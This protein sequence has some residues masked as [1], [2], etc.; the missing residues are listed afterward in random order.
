[1]ACAHATLGQATTAPRS[2]DLP[3]LLRA[4][5]L[6]NTSGL[7][8]GVLPQGITAHGIVWLKDVAFWDGT[9][10]VDLRGKDVFLQSFLGLAF[11]GTD[12][13]HYETVY[14]R[15]FNFRHADTLRRKW[16][17]QYMS[18]PDAPYNKLRAEH[19][20]T[21]ENAVDPVP[22]ATE[23]F[24]A[25][26]VIRDGWV[27]VYVNHSAKASLQVKAAVPLNGTLLGLWAD[28]LPGD[29]AHLTVTPDAGRA[30][31]DASQTS[32]TREAAQAAPDA[33]QTTPAG[34]TVVN[35][36][37]TR[38]TEPG[39]VHM[40]EVDGDGIAWI[41]GQ[42]LTDG[43]LEFDV[44]GKDVLQRSFVGI[45]FHGVNDSTFE[46][47]YFRPFNFRTDD[48]VR[49]THAVQYIAEPSYGWEKLRT[50]YPNK[51]EQPLAPAPDPN[52]WFHVRV[53][54][55]GSA[56]T[57]Y[58]NGASGPSLVVTSLVHTGGQKVGLWAGNGS[59]GDWRNIR[60]QR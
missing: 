41:K 10:D 58:V 27:S 38:G 32:Q 42:S 43:T 56:I 44:R 19:P 18:M 45:A 31:P 33:A 7:P 46:S 6:I 11:H 29:F 55:R 54:V 24:H 9:L 35:R 48:P 17:V 30:A 2:Y 60:V 59:G 47:I 34:Y 12:T 40:D 1:M 37:L 25:T 15:P 26:I 13:N 21:Y 53:V 23:W 4:G 5:K 22:V 20:L 16:S 8:I 14:F 39:A 3:G 36:M 52:E 49:K 51:Y 28:A 57:V 50:E